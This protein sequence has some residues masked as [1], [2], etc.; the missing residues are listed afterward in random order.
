[1]KTN[2]NSPIEA[3]FLVIRTFLGIRFGPLS[4]S[5]AA[6]F[7]AVILSFFAQKSAIARNS[8]STDI[9][10]RPG[11]NAIV[12]PA[13]IPSILTQSVKTGAPWAEGFNNAPQISKEVKETT[14]K[15]IKETNDGPSDWV[16]AIKALAW[17]LTI[18]VVAWVLSKEIRASLKL[19]PKLIRKISAGGVE[20]EVN[21]EVADKIRD[22]LR[23]SIDELTRKADEEYIRSASVQ[24]LD[25]HLQ[26]VFTRAL[27]RVLQS[28]GMEFERSNHRS[29][30]HVQDIVFKQ[31]L[32][33]ITDYF[34]RQG[35]KKQGRRFSQRFGSMG[36]AWRIGM[37]LGE[38]N[39]FSPGTPEEQLV[40][41][42]GMTREEAQ[43]AS[44]TSRPADLCVLLRSQADGNVAVGVLYIDSTREL[45]YGDDRAAT[46]V[47]GL[48]E[49]EPEVINLANAVARTMA[50]LRL[51]A[52]NLVIMEERS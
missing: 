9:R 38:G 22:Y 51:A 15:E 23:G 20:M 46:E 10:T 49:G 52:P 11:T 16:E 6:I 27:P 19:A 50:P 17:P 35:T 43:S 34:P 42:W 13:P 41:E 8:T 18:I 40:K 26:M 31:Y 7:S 21:A 1:M 4:V 37:S 44:R 32:Y 24:N 47:A 30:V 33:Q 14:S 3:I 28:R 5:A 48:L 29:T 25:Q 36:R 2:K 45:A 39:A 12:Q